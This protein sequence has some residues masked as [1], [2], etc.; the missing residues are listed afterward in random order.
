[1]PTVATI[2]TV[3]GVTILLDK[4]LTPDGRVPDQAMMEEEALTA[5]G[6]NGTRYRDVG[7]QF[8]EFTA[9]II[10]TA[11]TY[12][13]AVTRCRVW[14]RM[15]AT[16]IKLTISNMGSSA[17]YRYTRVHVVSHG[18]VV[19]PGSVANAAQPSHA[20]HLIGPVTLRLMEITA[21]LNP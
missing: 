11:A 15:Q 20:A 2:T 8:R 7:L 17:T 3:D 10:E 14:D 6:L 9:D 5:P 19:R 4:F 12:D 1:M 18:I 16:I 21:G 13:A